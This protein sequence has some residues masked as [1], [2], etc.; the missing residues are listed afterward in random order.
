M[1]LARLAYYAPPL[2]LEQVFSYIGKLSR[3]FVRGMFRPR[4]SIS[5]A[6]RGG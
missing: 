3:G 4:F 2:A 6:E 5:K 1:V